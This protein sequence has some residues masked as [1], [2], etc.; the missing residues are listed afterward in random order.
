MAA[1]RLH[2]GRHPRWQSHQRGNTWKRR[3]GLSQNRPCGPCGI[4][5]TQKFINFFEIFVG[6]YC[7][8]TQ[9]FLG[10]FML[11]GKLG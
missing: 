9:D 5:F 2:L 1:S 6:G 11:V 8:N 10:D 4:G 3:Q 7:K